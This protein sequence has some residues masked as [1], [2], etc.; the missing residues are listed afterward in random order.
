[1]PLNKNFGLA[2]FLTL[3][4][5]GGLQ[6]Q[7]AFREHEEPRDARNKGM[8]ILVHLVGVGF[9]L[10]GGDLADRFGN[11]ISA[12]AAVD[13]ITDHNLFIGA[14]AYYYF[15]QQVWEDPLD[16]IRNP[17]GSII[18]RDLAFA[19]VSLRNRGWYF[20]GRVGKLF[21]VGRRSRTGIRAAI[22]GGWMQ[23]KI[24]VQDD[25]ESVTQ[26]TGDYIK[27]YDR[28]TG[29]PAISQFI[30]WQ[31]LAED[32]RSNFYIGLEFHQGFTNTLRDWDFAERRK[33]DDNRIDLRF[34]IRAVWT[35]PLYIGKPQEIYY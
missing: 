2:I 24:R 26:L 25:S 8:A 16:P 30:G 33:L 14:E 28:L 34:G 5:A 4:T 32:R 35:L 7:K 19:S 6:A 13:L 27:G 21:P 12:G 9:H 17:D 10:P 11:D 22:G 23:H 1:M 31:K 15:G 3:S 18:G 20:G 29:G